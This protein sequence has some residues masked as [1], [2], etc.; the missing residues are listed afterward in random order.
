MAYVKTDAQHYSDIGA[1][2]RSKNRQATKYKPSEMAAAIREIAGFNKV[3]TF[4]QENDTVKSFI[5]NVTYD[6]TDYSTSQIENYSDGTQRVE[7]PNGAG[8]GIVSAG[9][10]VVTDMSNSGTFQRAVSGGSETVY[11]IA[12]TKGGTFYVIKS[13]G[14]VAE[15]GFIKPTGQV[16]YIYL[17]TYIQNIRDLGG[18]ASDG[19]KLKYGLIFRG[20]ELSGEMWQ[21]EISAQ[22]IQ[23]MRDLLRIGYDVDLRGDAEV[24]GTDG[25]IDTDDD[26]NSPLGVGYIRC[27]IEQYLGMKLSNDTTQYHKVLMQI[28]ENAIKGIPQYIHCVYGTDRTGTI[29]M[30]LEAL[31]G[32]SQSDMDKDYELSTFATFKRRRNQDNW[33]NTIAYI[34]T[35]PG[36]SFR[37]RVAY[38]ALKIGIPLAT[39]NAFRRAV[40][41]G[42]PEDLNISATVTYNVTNHLTN[43]STSNQ[44]ATI[45]SDQTYTATITPISN[46]EIKN[47]NVLIKVGGVNVTSTAYKNGVITITKPDGDIE[48]TITATKVTLYDDLALGGTWLYNKR[49]NSSGTQ[50]DANGY[51]VWISDEISLESY[52]TNPVVAHVRMNP[53]ID[54]ATDDNLR[55]LGF[56]SHYFTTGSALNPALYKKG[57]ITA[58]ANGDVQYDVGWFTDYNVDANYQQKWNYS[59]YKYIGLVIPVNV[60]TAITE[61]NKPELH[62]ALNELIKEL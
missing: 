14:T 52:G 24:D 27:P 46:Y 4:S 2:I 60:G 56:T 8:L 33:K 1:A 16:R 45:K 13:D 39:I 25:V 6:P 7:A 5:E 19:G 36:N 10:L 57:H 42:N 34:N 11:N 37:D 18:W 20:S 61:A 50:L 44:A 58:D 9:E 29:C 32:V 40:I 41:D 35:L 51:A 30:I 43:C 53:Q 54:F 55:V 48:I 23:Q 15:S 12:P 3:I 62:Y 49:Y 28:M 47:N 22:D 26:Y 21:P 31:C 38:W 17:S 59:T